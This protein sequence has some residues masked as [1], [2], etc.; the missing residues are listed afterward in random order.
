MR[1]TASR[2]A[3]SWCCASR[4]RSKTRCR[5]ASTFIVRCRSGAPRCDRR[6]GRAR[7]ARSS[8]LTRPP[9]MPSAIASTMTAICAASPNFI[10]D[11][12]GA[13]ILS[14]GH[15]LELIKDLGDAEQ[16]YRQYA[17]ERFRRHARHRPHPH[18]DRI[19][20][21]HPLGASLLGLSR[22]P[23]SR[24]C[25]TASSPITGTAAAR[26]SGAATASCRTA[27]PN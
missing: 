13:E 20:R 6:L 11:V 4:S 27:T 8:R 23:T 2:V 22:S 24:S 12:E 5:R 25:I 15:G 9:N 18:G 16:V 10:E 1:S 17:L 26:W 19:G 21:R 3:R 14:I 7:R